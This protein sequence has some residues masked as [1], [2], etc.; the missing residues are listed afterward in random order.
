MPPLTPLVKK[1]IVGLLVA[2]VAELLLQNFANVNVIGVLALDPIHL[3]L[4]TP[5]QLVTYVLI[6][7][8][9]VMSMLIGLFF[10]WLILSPFEVTFGSRHTLELIFC[11]MVA[12]A[13]AVILVAQIAPT[14]AY[15]FF[16]SHPIAYA[17]MAAMTQVVR[18]G[19]IMFFGVIPMTSQTLLLVLGGLSLLQFLAT[20]D[21]LMLAGSLGAM[22]AGIGYVRYMARA[23]RPPRRKSSSPP[24]FRVLRG[25]GGSGDGD[26]ERPKWLN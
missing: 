19:R 24:R 23:P 2:F 8:P 7:G 15:L 1:L 4:L 25:G 10:M 9:Q 21:H 26:S 17:G 6:E 3:G 16:G 13:L 14:P 20:K 18:S 12:A 5:L 22:A 11:G